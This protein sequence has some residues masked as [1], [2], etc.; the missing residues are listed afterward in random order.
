MVDSC[1]PNFVYLQGE[2]LPHDEVG[3]LVWAGAHLS[4]AE[5]VAGLFGSVLPTTVCDLFTLICQVIVLS[6]ILLIYHEFVF[7]CYFCLFE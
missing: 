1:Q 3:S 2:Q 4:T 5:A 7:A 6:K